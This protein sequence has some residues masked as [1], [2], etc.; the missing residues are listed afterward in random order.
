MTMMICK[1]GTELGIREAVEYLERRYG[2]PASDIH[3]VTVSAEVGQP[4]RLSV[5]LYWQ[6]EGLVTVDVPADEHEITTLDQ[7]DRSFLRP[8]GTVRREPRT[9]DVPLLNHD[10]SDRWTGGDRKDE[11]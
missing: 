6:T 7:P 9:V 4:I 5:D 3:A 11:P 2:I 8:D 1:D 10:D